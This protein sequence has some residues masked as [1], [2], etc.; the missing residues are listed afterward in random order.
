MTFGMNGEVA[1]YHSK[2]PW[3]G[4]V[5]QNPTK[6]TPLIS[7]LIVIDFLVS[8]WSYTKCV[9]IL[10]IL[11]IKGPGSIATLLNIF[12]RKSVDIPS[13]EWL[14]DYHAN[15]ISFHWHTFTLCDLKHF[16]NHCFVSDTTS[17]IPIK[18]YTQSVWFCSYSFF[19]FLIFNKFRYE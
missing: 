11:T 6:R 13:L 19:I 2:E 7:K 10:V 1:E 9:I 14:S 12:C 3:E 8:I 5:Q 4:A 17:K 18:S 15:V 16:W